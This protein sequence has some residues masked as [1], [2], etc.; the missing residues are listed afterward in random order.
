[1]PKKRIM[2]FTVNGRIVNNKDKFMKLLSKITVHLIGPKTKT[3]PRKYS[4]LKQIFVKSVNSF[5][6]RHQLTH[7]QGEEVKQR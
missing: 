3:K 6:L 2:M 7:F 1:M 5:R 4:L